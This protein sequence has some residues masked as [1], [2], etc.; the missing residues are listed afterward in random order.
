MRISGR[1]GDRVQAGIV[2][3]CRCQKI[4]SLIWCG[5]S[6]PKGRECCPELHLHLIVSQVLHCLSEPSLSG[7]RGR[8]NPESVSGEQTS[9][10]VLQSLLGR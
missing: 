6:G 4:F 8:E 7:H 9:F 1:A 5:R 10:L 3:Y 2:P